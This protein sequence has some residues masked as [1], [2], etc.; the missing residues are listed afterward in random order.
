MRALN[1]RGA[2]RR[3]RQRGAAVTELALVAPLLVTIL[4]FGLYFSELI[5]AKLK[6]LEAARFATFEL[7]SHAL[8]DYG[9]TAVNRHDRAFGEARD[10][11]VT[12]SLQK[13]RDLDS[14][15]DRPAGGLIAGY[16]AF[17]TNLENQ[18]VTLDATFSTVMARGMP[19]PPRTL[20]GTASQ[21]HQLF[22]FNQK[23]KVQA[24]VTVRLDN[25]ILPRNFLNDP[26]GFFKA[27]QWG[28]SE[29]QSVRL[30]SRFTMIASGWALPDGADAVMQKDE[31]VGGRVAGLHRGSSTHGLWMQVNRMAHF[32]TRQ[33]ETDLVGLQSIDVAS[34]LLPHP[35]SSTFV[36]SHNYGLPNALDRGCTSSPG[37]ADPSH[38]APSGMNNLHVASE[39]D[40][41]YR[42]CYDTAPFRDTAAY[43]D[44]LYVQQYVN[45]GDHFMGCLN[46]QADDP[47]HAGRS[48]WGRGDLNRRKV[49]C[50]GA[51]R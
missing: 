1:A 14:V 30:K 2:R 49:D 24:E 20:D 19:L 33:A 12:D 3:A 51:G 31:S 7:T 18:P 48:P 50:G 4:L 39:L 11:T 17:T 45:R 27:D 46:P 36:V 16:S 44:A 26:R 34:F 32:G 29:L 28:G 41:P 15:A 6:L 25:R 21:V 38:P 8:D 5:R 13:F 22:G 47:S 43:D 42:K 37:N 23:G 10:L 40:T 9:G 35:Y